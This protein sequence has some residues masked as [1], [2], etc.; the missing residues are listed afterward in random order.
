M[1]QAQLP[2]P[3]YIAAGEQNP[4]QLLRLMDTDKKGKV[5]KAEFMA[6]ME[7]EFDRVDVNHDGQ[8]NGKN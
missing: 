2:P 8:L 7:A 5:S 6:Y 1:Q 4:K 3:E